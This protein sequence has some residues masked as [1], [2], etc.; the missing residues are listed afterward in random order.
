MASKSFDINELYLQ[1]FP[2]KLLVG[3]VMILAILGIAYFALYKSQKIELEGLEAKEVQLKDE[4]STKAQKAASLP[5][6]KKELAQ[7]EEAFGIL[8]KQLPTGAEIP[9][10]LQELNQA[11]SNN[12]LQMSSTKPLKTE[13]DGP[14]EVLPYSIS[15]NGSYEQFSSFAKDVGGL[16]R[17]VVLNS[18]NV[19]NDKN[20]RLLLEAKANTYKAA[21]GYVGNK[22]QQKPVENKAEEAK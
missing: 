10:L 5:E 8:V 6:L 14:I 1:S 12:S 13:P 16:S 20:G 11:G 3:V 15:T 21:E 18:L 9:N 22:Q 17:I 2:V 19:S 4:F 7:I